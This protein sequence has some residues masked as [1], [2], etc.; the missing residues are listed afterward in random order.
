MRLIVFVSIVPLIETELGDRF[1]RNIIAQDIDKV[2]LAGSDSIQRDTYI[3]AL[4]MKLKLQ[5]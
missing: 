3:S 5:L 2:M 1:L 4:I